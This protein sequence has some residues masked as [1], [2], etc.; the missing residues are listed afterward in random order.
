[1]TASRQ[2]EILG[3]LPD[4]TRVPN[5]NSSSDCDGYHTRTIGPKERIRKTL[6]TFF[7]AVDETT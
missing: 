6:W 4:G 7:C 5:A 1:M 3:Y 2:T